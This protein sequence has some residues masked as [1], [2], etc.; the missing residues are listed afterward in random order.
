MEKKRT[1]IMSR[2]QGR[3]EAER[4]MNLEQ[5]IH[6]RFSE[7]ESLQEALVKYH[8]KPAVFSPVPPDSGSAGWG[9]RAQYPRL[10]YSFDLQANEERKSA[11]SLQVSLVCQNTEEVI[12]ERIEVMVR[13]CLRD[14][15][16]KPE[17]DTLYAFTWARTDPFSM[18]EDDKRLLIGSDIRFDILEY[19]SQETT[20]PDPVAAVNRYVKKLFP[21]SIVIG[22]DRMEDTTVASGKRPVIYCRL[23]SLNKAE[24]TNTVAWMEGMIALHILCPETDRRVKM[25][26]AVANQM[27]LDGEIIMLDHSPMFIRRLQADYQSDYLKAGQ[28]FVTGKYGLLRYHAKPHGLSSVGCRF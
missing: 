12:P 3:R 8:G 13:E 18:E 19:A 9:G 4:Q 21:E 28:V 14:V 20:D 7:S 24:E 17:G 16:L 22:L 25:A 2:G 26:A 27:S 5:L 23:A 10:I 11:G 6:R 1:L 15:L